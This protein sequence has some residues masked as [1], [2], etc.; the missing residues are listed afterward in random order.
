MLHEPLP[1][2]E[3]EEKERL[4]EEEEL[5]TRE[6]R[7]L[8]ESKKRLGE[9]HRLEYLQNYLGSVTGSNYRLVVSSSF[10]YTINN[11]LNK[12]TSKGSKPGQGKTT[13]PSKLH[14]VSAGSVIVA[15]T[16]KTMSN[17]MNGSISKN[18]GKSHTE[19]SSPVSA[20]TKTNSRK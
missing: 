19:D 5:R 15:P 18:T 10:I 8:E 4:E 12:Q 20:S 6:L 11:I 14:R 13:G 1:N 9:D 17:P 16:K 2:C 3:E 7:E